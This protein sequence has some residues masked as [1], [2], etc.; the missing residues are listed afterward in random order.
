MKLSR[1]AVA[2]GSFAAL[3]AGTGFEFQRR[4]RAH[5]SRS[6]PNTVVATVVEYEIVGG[7]DPVA[8]ATVAIENTRSPAVTLSDVRVSITADGEII[9]AGHEAVEFELNRGDTETVAVD[10]VSAPE[11]EAYE[12]DLDDRDDL[13]RG[14]SGT[15][16]VWL[17]HERIEYPISGEPV[18]R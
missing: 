16:V 8:H 12:D 3:F 17:V 1:R 2:I 14:V 7:D 5:V 6:D 13:Q 4:V 15:V 10:L 11:Y 18:D 9:A